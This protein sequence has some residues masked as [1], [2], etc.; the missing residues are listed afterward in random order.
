M[1]ERL[2]TFYGW[3]VVGPP[4]ARE[5]VPPTRYESGEGQ[6]VRKDIRS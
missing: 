6:V 3:R 2:K 1:R 4:D 5:L